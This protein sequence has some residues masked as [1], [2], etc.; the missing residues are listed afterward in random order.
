MT[1]APGSGHALREIVF[2][3]DVKI[4]KFHAFDFFGDGS[5]YLLDVPGHA[6]GPMSGLARTAPTTFVLLGADTF[7]LAGSLRPSQYTPL[8]ET[9]DSLEAGL[10]EFFPAPCPCSIFGD[11]HP[12][13]ESARTNPYYTA[14]RAPGSAYVDPETADRSIQELIEFDAGEDVLVCLAHDPGLF[15]VLPLFNANPE[16][17]INDWQEKGYKEKTRWRFLNELPRDGKPGREP[18]ISGLWRDG[19]ELSVQEAMAK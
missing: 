12:S 8:P 17:N 18:V 5:F 4:G 1:D 15:E 19:R 6:T 9:L 10:D 16:S 11:C 14:S 3:P 2:D 7:H 13:P